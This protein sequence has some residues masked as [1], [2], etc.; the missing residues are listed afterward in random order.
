[1][2]HSEQCTLNMGLTC[3]LWVRK[4]QPAFVTTPIAPETEQKA[5]VACE[6]NS[7]TEDIVSLVH[8]FVPLHHLVCAN[9]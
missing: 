7:S 1:M 5:A 6:G 8:G 9:A 3:C 4:K 2:L